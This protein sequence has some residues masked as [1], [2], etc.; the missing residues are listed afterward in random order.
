MKVLL[1]W[2]SFFSP[3]NPLCAQDKD[4]ASTTTKLNSPNFYL[5]HKLGD[6]L[7]AVEHKQSIA[8]SLQQITQ[9]PGRLDQAHSPA[10][11]NSTTLSQADS[12]LFENGGEAGGF[13]RRS[14]VFLQQGQTVPNQDRAPV[15]EFKAKKDLPILIGGTAMMV[16]GFHM[17]SK[18]P[19]LTEAQLATLD[20][21]T[22][23]AFDRGATDNVRHLD[24]KLSDYMVGISALTPF[25]VL[26]SRAI[27]Q[28]GVAVMVMYYE[29]AVLTGGL[30]NFGKGLF[31]RKRPYVYNL[32]TPL[33]DRTKV[34]ARHS[35]FSGHVASSAAFTYLTAFMVN[36][37]A[38]SPGMKWAAWSGA[39]V[40]PGTIAV[41][42]YTSG[43]HFPTDVLAGYVV[44]A[45]TG[46]LI[47]WLHRRELPKDMSLNIQP[48]PY[49]MHMVLTF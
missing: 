23:N 29:T 25:T 37:Y 43:K 19:P 17:K 48:T 39:V 13:L 40:I 30:I 38:D 28:E 27:R 5:S 7:Q 15:F 35:F 21:G 47:P 33:E 20:P 6:S 44:G 22:I 26:A 2:L 11:G 8:D 12:S 9:T 31:R 42:R 49:G 10:Y 36:R 18:V 4:Y 45:G 16:A 34:S 1:L 14:T 41:W 3:L 24:S 46:L 32:N